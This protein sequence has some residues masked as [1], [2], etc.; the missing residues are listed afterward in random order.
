MLPAAPGNPIPAAPPLFR[1]LLVEPEQGVRILADEQMDLDLAAESRHDPDT[2]NQLIAAGFVA[3]HARVWTAADGRQIHAD[4]FLFQ[5]PAG[6]LEFQRQ[7]NRYACRFANE[8]FA[9]PLSGVG[10]Q[11]RWSSQG[12]PI[13]E[14]VSWVAGNRRYLVSVR[15]LAPPH[16]HGR[17]LRIAQLAIKQAGL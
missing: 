6:A 4:V 7:V 3:A 17:I 16:D 9:G 1:A 2:R 13:E 10:L 5:D 11:V 15:A 8:A 12:D 14:Q